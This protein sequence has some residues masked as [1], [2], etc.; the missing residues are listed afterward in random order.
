MSFFSHTPLKYKINNIKT[1]LHR[2]YKLSSSYLT[3]H[4]E[5][6]FL[7]NFFTNN[8]YPVG[9][10]EK[11]CKN[12]LNN[13]YRIPTQLLT[14]NK[15]TIFISLPYYGPESE[16]IYTK[17]LNSLSD[18]YPQI[19][20]NLALKN[21]FTIGSLFRFKDQVSSEVRSGIIYCYSCD[22]CKASYVGSTKRRFRE[23]VDQH[24]GISSRTARHLTTVTH[25]IPR[26]HAE[27]HNHPLNSRPPIKTF[28]EHSTDSL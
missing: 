28:P 10:F 5:I 19:K 18:Y 26:K 3:L 16:T 14:A 24:L 27:D 17:L 2:A 25:S 12:F 23:R 4:Q 11:Q 22:S 21:N 1:L 13:I 20:F 8:G 15:K 7:R 6:E 9:I